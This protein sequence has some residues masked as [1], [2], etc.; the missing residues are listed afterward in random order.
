MLPFVMLFFCAGIMVSYYL[1]S[2]YNSSLFAML[3]S[4]KISG[5]IIVVLCSI[6]LYYMG[7]CFTVWRTANP[8]Q[9]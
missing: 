3:N 7:Y 4:T 9:L 2:Q 6:A 1:S 5:C 8:N